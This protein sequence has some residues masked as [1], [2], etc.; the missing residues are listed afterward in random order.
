M[1]LQF[2]RDKEML[3]LFVIVMGGIQDSIQQFKWVMHSFRFKIKH[4]VSFFQNLQ[5]CIVP[6]FLVSEQKVRAKAGK[7]FHPGTPGVRL[8]LCSPSCCCHQLWKEHWAALCFPSPSYLLQPQHLLS[9]LLLIPI[10]TDLSHP[11]LYTD[12]SHTAARS[13]V[14]HKQ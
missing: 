5:G 12:A 6:N 9:L 13:T 8:R 11:C 14:V 1:H 3:L 4:M 10:P 7:Y 2:G